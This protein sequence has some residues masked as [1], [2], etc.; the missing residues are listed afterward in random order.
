MFINKEFTPQIN[1]F[2][3]ESFAD[4][5]MQ[6]KI[7]ESRFYKK[8]IAS[9]VLVNTL[10]TN[11]GL[12]SST[13]ESFLSKR[14]KKIFTYFDLEASLEF[15]TIE[16]KINKLKFILESFDFENNTNDDI[17]PKVV[18]KHNNLY[19]KLLFESGLSEIIKATNNIKQLLNNSTEFSDY[20]KYTG[21]HEFNDLSNRKND[22]MKLMKYHV[23]LPQVV[24]DSMVSEIERIKKEA[25][26][27]DFGEFNFM[28]SNKTLQTILKFNARKDMGISRVRQ[29]KTLRQKA[30]KFKIGIN[31]IEG[32]KFTEMNVRDLLKT[33]KKREAYQE[34]VYS[35]LITNL[36]IFIKG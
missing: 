26:I 3:I 14:K 28:I 22:L 16:F 34:T 10:G 11:T 31:K 13:I 30:V 32:S 36:A 21:E 8:Y 20:F 7:K 9:K 19:I 12:A 24:I 23:T 27:T 2:L 29:L 15:E 25:Y 5:L 35:P 4:N 17:G 6:E 33:T 18:T 1:K